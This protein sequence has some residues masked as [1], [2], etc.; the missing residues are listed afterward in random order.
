M[1]W[2][3]T[4]TV[5]IAHGSNT[6]Q[7]TGTNWIEQKSG[8]AMVIE[9][10]P[11]LVEIDAVVS[12]TE[13]RLVDPIEGQGSGLGY[14]IIPTQGLSIRLIGYFDRLIEELNA[15]R[16]AWKT[17]F[18]T[19]SATAY[20][21][22]IDQ[23]NAGTVNDF[24]QAIR[25][26][27]GIQGPQGVQGERGIQGEQGV[28]GERGE[29][30]IQGVQ[31]IQGEQGEQGVRGD[32]GDTG[33]GLNIKG[34]LADVAALP[35]SGT[36][37]DAWSVQGDIFVWDD[38][39]AEWDDAGPLR[40]PEGPRGQQGI[41]GPRGPQGEVGPV[42]PVGPQGMQGIQGPQG[43]KG[44]TGL[45]GPSVFEVWRQSRGGVG[46][47]EEYHDFLS[48]QTVS[49]ARAQ[50]DAASADRAAAETA[51]IASEAA[52]AEAQAAAASATQSAQVLSDN[53][54]IVRLLQQH[55]VR[56][57]LNLDI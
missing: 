10:V 1:T 37:G 55:R 3:R 22:W 15:T 27:Q 11:G 4:G 7:G 45:T 36:A 5:E 2:Y 31:G 34:T 29:Q 25:G 46:T 14:A 33:A 53:A 19:F 43:D 51:R 56:A 12:A 41:Q 44:D 30:G 17:V 9:G 49:L 35:G 16:A 39:N 20:Q 32:K 8:W 24:L 57:L 6:I 13:L 42:G 26:E 23:G 21:L 47:L 38:I 48:D 54:E 18:S 28:Q 40:G 52:E 50:A